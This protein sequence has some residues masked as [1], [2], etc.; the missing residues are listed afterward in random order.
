MKTWTLF[1]TLMT[2]GASAT[3]GAEYS[4]PLTAAPNLKADVKQVVFDELW[5]RKEL[6][7]RDRSLVTVTAIVAQGHL[8][9]LPFQFTLALHNGVTP[10]ELAGLLTHIA[11]YS[12]VTA[13]SEA[14]AVLA[15][16]FRQEDVDFAS[17]QRVQAQPVADE[18]AARAQRQV[19]E[20]MVGDVSPGLAH[21]SNTALNGDLWL[22]DDLTPRDRSLVTF[23]ALI[24]QGN[25]EQL[26]VHVNKGIGNG[27]LR[28]EIGE[29]IAQLAFY[30]GWPRAFSAATTVKSMQLAD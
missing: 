8:R 28:R 20:S 26:P 29:V 18:A 27:L 15:Q 23:S 19:V 5:E 9:E 3:A 4:S 17:L 16:V 30:A 14:E 6:S 24:T 21:F 7:K 11:Y 25:V 13:A 12:G 22:R 2:A 1:L 10:Q